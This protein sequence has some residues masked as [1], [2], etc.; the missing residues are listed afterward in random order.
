MTGKLQKKIS[1]VISLIESGTSFQLIASK[2][3][4]VNSSERS[5][6]Q[7]WILEDDLDFETRKIL[8]GM[9]TGEVNKNIKIDNGYK[10]IKLNKKRKIWK[11]RFKI[12]FPKIFLFGKK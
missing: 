1:T 9:K 12:E 5:F 2:F 4:D 8:E 6:R 3:S 7:N 11:P 10:L